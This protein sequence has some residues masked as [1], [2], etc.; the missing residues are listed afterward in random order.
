MIFGYLLETFLGFSF[1]LGLEFIRSTPKP[2]IESDPRWQKLKRL[3][4]V[5]LKGYSVFF[6]CAIYFAASIQIACVVVLVRK[7]FG[8]SVNGLGGLVVQITWAVTLLSMLPLLYPLVMLGIF[9]SK[10]PPEC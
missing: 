5:L 8:I 2:T 1:A 3:K 7:D 10:E 6:E 9:V 4:E